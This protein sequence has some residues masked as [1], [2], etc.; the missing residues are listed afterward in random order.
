MIY[1]SVRKSLKV[2]ALV[3]C[4]I[5]VTGFEKSHLSHTQQQDTLFSPSNN[6]STHLLI[7]QGGIGAESF[8][9]C[10]CCGLFLRLVRC[11]RALGLSSKCSISPWQADSRQ[12]F[13]T[14]LADELAMNLAAL[15]DI[16]RQKWHQWMPFGCFQS[17]CSLCP[18]LHGYPPSHLYEC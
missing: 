2:M 4:M 14:G 10:F 13:T 18:P 9:G 17:R 3:V 5:Y 6:N 1:D 15:C 11:P 8:P 16:W 12:Q 7:F